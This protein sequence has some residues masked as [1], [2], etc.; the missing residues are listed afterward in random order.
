MKQISQ[1][2]SLFAF[3]REHLSHTDLPQTLL[4]EKNEFF[5]RKINNFE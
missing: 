1:I 3:F 4:E 2:L 5:T